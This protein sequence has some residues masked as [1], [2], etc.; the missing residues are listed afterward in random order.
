MIYG[1]VKTVNNKT[2]QYCE[3]LLFV[4]LKTI[5]YDKVS[6]KGGRIIQD[7]ISFFEPEEHETATNKD[8]LEL[9]G[10]MG[11]M[12][13][14][15]NLTEGQILSRFIWDERMFL[16]RSRS[17]SGLGF[18]LKLHEKNPDDPLSP[19]YVDLSL[20]QSFPDSLECVARL[21]A[22][23]VPTVD[24]DLVAGI[25]HGGVPFATAMSIRTRKP[26]ITPRPEKKS[27]GAGNMIDGKFERGQRVLLIDDLI[28]TAN[29]KFEAIEVLEASGLII[30]ALVVVVDREQGGRE[31][32]ESQNY[33]LHSIFAVTELMDE[34]R[35]MGLLSEELYQEIQAYRASE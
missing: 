17:E 22:S 30:S 23:A 6:F 2:S 32:L 25:P 8:S 4:F 24:Y 15:F 1:P 27:H 11:I 12:Q 19:Y 9:W 28:T 33:H 26:M 18:K 16:D 3:V 20:M 14:Y 5:L 29:T 13:S 31:E 35:E 10:G 21:F 7:S 34:Y